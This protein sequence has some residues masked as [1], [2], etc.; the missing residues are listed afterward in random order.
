MQAKEVVDWLRRTGTRR[1][2][3]GMAR[4]GLP[5]ARAFG[6]PVG[7]MQARAKAIGRDHAL[8]EALWRTGWY[9]ARMMAAFLGEPDRLTRRGMDAWARDFDNWGIT[10]TVCLHLFDRTPLAW[11]RAPRWAASP[12]EFVKRGGF[13]L[14]A[15]LAVHDEAA[16]DARFLALLPLIEEA[17]PDERNFVKKGVSWALRAIGRRRPRLNAAC[18]ALARRLAVSGAPAARWVGKDALRDFARVAA[19]KA[20]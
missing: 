19:R 4:Y 5:S 11:D 13:A 9:E 14:M 17:A 7:V 18:S 8:A 15:A 16:P 2:R 10:D 20:G 12:R 1:N 3:E 6:V